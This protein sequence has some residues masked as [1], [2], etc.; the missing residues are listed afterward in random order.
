[1]GIDTSFYYPGVSVST[2]VGN[3]GVWM[4]ISLIVAIIGGFTLYFVF[5]KKENKFEGF[6][7]WAHD[8]FNFKTLL[9]EDILKVCYLILTIYITL[10]SFGLIAVNFLAF[11]LML[12]VGNLV[13]R[14]VY[15]AAILLIKICQNTSEINKK[16]KK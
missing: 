5:F 16:L 12:V 7:K 10:S 2:S 11:I 13:L 14:V 8:F 6:L 9:L 3:A 1:M 4:L 15:E